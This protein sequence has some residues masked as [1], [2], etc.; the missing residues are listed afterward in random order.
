MWAFT[1]FV[2][3]LVFGFGS[4]LTLLTGW[5]KTGHDAEIRAIELEHE[6]L[7]ERERAVATERGNVERLQSLAPQLKS[8][9]KETYG[10]GTMRHKHVLSVS[11]YTITLLE[12]KLL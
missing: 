12:M 3:A 2:L 6:R 9:L 10:Y 1:L 5:A 8:V 7:M 11:D 4:G